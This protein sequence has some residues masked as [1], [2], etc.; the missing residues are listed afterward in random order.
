[1]CFLYV[2]ASIFVIITDSLFFSLIQHRF[3]W[4]V[5]I[6]CQCNVQNGECLKIKN[7]RDRKKNGKTLQKRGKID[8]HNWNEIAIYLFAIDAAQRVQEEIEKQ[9]EDSCRFLLQTISNNPRTCVPM[10]YCYWMATD[11]EY[12]VYRLN[13]ENVNKYS[14]IY[15]FFSQLT[16]FPNHWQAAK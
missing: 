9:C 14:Q 12:N 11:G 16:Q 15:T 1:M 2:I 5:Y 4:R 3:R 13:V 7:M 6:L 8:A 10:Y